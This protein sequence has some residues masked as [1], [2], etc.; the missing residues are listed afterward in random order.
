MTLI[1]R[2]NAAKA[3]LTGQPNNSFLK[4]ATR[5]MPTFGEPPR[6]STADWIEL[7]NKSPRM[8]PIHQIASDV[9]TSVYGIY[10][11]GDTK[12]IKLVGND[13]EK[14]LK[15]P[16][17]NQ[18]ITGYVLFYI[19]MAYL[20]LPAGEAFWLKERNGL[21]KVTEL[22]PVPP[23]WINEIPSISKPYFTIH[24]LGN[25]NSS[26]IHVLP[27]D[28]VYFKKPDV[29]NPYLRGIGRAEGIGDEI[30]TDEYMA[31]YAKRYFFNDAI[32]NMVIQMPGAD[33][34][35]VDRTEEKW[36]QKYG[37]YNNK[38]KTAF[39]NWD[40]KAQILKET[41]TEMDFI[42]SRK[43][44]RDL[45]NQHFCIPPEL[46]GIL[47]NSNRS[48]IDAAYYLYTKNVLRKELKFIDDTLN[49]QL[50]PEFAKDE[51]LEHDNVVPEDE[52]FKLKKASEGL[53]NGGITVDEWRRANGWEELPDGKGKILYT[54]LNMI[55]TPLDESAIVVNMEPQQQE[56]PNTGPPEKAVKKKLTPEHKNQ[57]WYVFDKAAVKNERSFETTV[58]R[59]FQGQ[60]YRVNAALEKGAKAIMKQNEDELLD[61]DEEDA[62]FAAALSALWLASMKEG[63]E[64]ANETYGLGLSWDVFNP[65]FKTFVEKYGLNQAKDI[66]ETTRDKLRKTLSEGIE[67]GESIP[68]LRDRVSQVFTEA[69]TSRARKIA[70]TETHNTVGYGTFETYKGANLQKKEWLTTIDGREREWHAAINGEV[71]DIDKPFSNGL[72]FPGDASGPAEEVVNCRCV[73]LPILPE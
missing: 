19:T 18:T 6:R 48:T 42:E 4:M 12:K 17:P 54:P 50:V 60:Q 72:M 34:T 59:F 58:K 5:F 1:D 49:V 3:A 25:M 55:P 15:K 73:L 9:A 7:Y 43:Y 41:Y 69:K 20:L 51:Y 2:F 53:K 13:V 62:L 64:V 33:E 66:N 27:D 35:V 70:I 56:L 37:G 52:E 45:S 71:V 16:N 44:L 63:F 22:W 23:N 57:M 40:M 32:P 47:E 31:K 46:F 68:K 8:N 24:P 38:H 30:E 39:V 61:W 67:A 11:V 28:M 29:T 36:N 65:R 10:K 21:G 26:P 14:I